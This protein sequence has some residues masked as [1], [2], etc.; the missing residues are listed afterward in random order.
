MK[1]CAGAGLSLPLKEKRLVVLEHLTLAEGRGPRPSPPRSRVLGLA[2]VLI[3][4]VKTN[5]NL[6]RGT[7]TFREK[8]P[9]A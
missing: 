5:E 7:K 1:S 9:V 6:A 3:V 2:E 8:A 4:D